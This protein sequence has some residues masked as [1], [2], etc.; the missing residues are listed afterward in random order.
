MNY[1]RLKS[2][3]FSGTLS[4]TVAARGLARQAFADEMAG[5]SPGDVCLAA[6]PGE[7]PTKPQPAHRASRLH[8]CG[9]HAD[10]ALDPSKAS[11]WASQELAKRTA[12]QAI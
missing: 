2:S 10:V 11:S 6:K 5:A 9:R 4:P 1:L 8:T 12:P 3:W 7:S